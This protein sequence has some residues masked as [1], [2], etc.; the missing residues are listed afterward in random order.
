MRTGMGGAAALSLIALVGLTRA[1]RA[2]DADT[3]GAG[4]RGTAMAGALVAGADDGSAAYYNPA[5]L[6]LGARSG[7]TQLSIGYATGLPFVYV[8]RTLDDKEHQQYSTYLPPSQGWVTAAGLF[9]LGGKI[10]RDRAALG[11]YLDDPQNDLVRV[12]LL[13]PHDPQFLRYQADPNRLELATS[14]GV[15][16]GDKV[17]AGIGVN[18]LAGIGGTA[19]FDMDLFGKQVRHR[20]LDFTLK[21]TAAPIVGLTVTP[22]DRLRFS[23]AYHGA[24]SLPVVENSA[25]G[26]GDLGTLLLDVSGVVQYSPHELAVGA[27]VAP[28]DHLRIDA[29]LRYEMWN[30]APYPAAQIKVDATG[31]VLHSLG[32][33]QALSM[34]T[35]D[36]P[37][38]FQATLVPSVAVE[39]TLPDGVTTLRAGYSF[40]PTYVD[41][42]VLPDSN[43]LD[44][45][46]HIVGLGASFQFRDPTEVFSQPLRLELAAQGQFFQPRTVKKEQGTADPVGDY[47]FGGAVLA[48]A[49]TLRYDF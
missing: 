27:M 17:A 18:V 5:G 42:Q 14:L 12:E 36:P 49:A 26:L 24:L 22:T 31:D 32:L 6:A 47:T 15:R 39:A 33:D 46:A 2:S 28:T 16:F 29:D 48:L 43:F 1:A 44:N 35:K 41:D 10:I 34:Q 7:R 37:A 11:F 4:P 19:D 45:D 30:L 13:D 9:P 38:P 40:R 20:K 8:H 3:Y 21:T 23:F 25:I